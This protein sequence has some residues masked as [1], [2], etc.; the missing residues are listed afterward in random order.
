VDPRSRT[1][2]YAALRLDVDNWRWAGVPFY[3]RTG[4]RLPRRVT[5]VVLQFQRP[6]HLPISAGQARG[7]EP[8]ALILHIQP[9]EGITLRFGAKVPGHRRL[10][11][12]RRGQLARGRRPAGRTPW[13]PAGRT[14]WP[15]TRGPPRFVPIGPPS[16]C[17]DSVTPRTAGTVATLPRQARP[18][19]HAA[20]VAAARRTRRGQHGNVPHENRR[21]DCL[22]RCGGRFEL[23]ISTGEHS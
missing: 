15:L 11:T 17:S 16:Y 1:E 23:L 5:E 20:S 10:A 12:L 22:R 21:V 3:V 6:P 4:K 18:N 14:N 8:D 19:G 7:L 13:P 9:D 2:T